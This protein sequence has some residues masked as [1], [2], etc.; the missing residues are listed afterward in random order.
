MEHLRKNQ[1]LQS[2]VKEMS[3]MPYQEITYNINKTE[4]AN[5]E[6]WVSNKMQAENKFFLINY[7]GNSP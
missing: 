6:K 3:I 2:R 1:S 4:L 5:F 7:K